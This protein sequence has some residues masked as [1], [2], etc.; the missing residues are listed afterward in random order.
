MVSFMELVKTGVYKVFISL[1]PAVITVGGHEI[2]IDILF[3]SIFRHTKTILAFSYIFDDIR[4]YTCLLIHFTQCRVLIVF[5]FFY[6]TLRQNPALI[7][8]LIGFVQGQYLSPIYYHPAT[9]R[10]FNHSAS[11]PVKPF[12]GSALCFVGISITL[13]GY[14]C[15]G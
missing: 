13:F 11:P 8:V 10:C 7:F 15:K 2:P 9:A 5:A 3:H 1:R 12:S 6:C 4:D 14:L